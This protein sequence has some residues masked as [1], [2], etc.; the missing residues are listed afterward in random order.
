[1]LRYCRAGVALRYSHNQQ[2]KSY[3]TCWVDGG[4]QYGCFVAVNNQLTTLAEATT[5]DAIQAGQTNRVVLQT[6]GQQIKLLIN[7]K[8]VASFAND[9]VATGVPALYVENFDGAAGASFDNLALYLP[10]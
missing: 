7:G 2:D 6:A 8:L 1:M 5:S 3:I 4:N 9:Q 10:K